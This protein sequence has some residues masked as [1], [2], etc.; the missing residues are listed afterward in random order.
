MER[1]TGTYGTITINADGTYPMH[2]LQQ[3]ILVKIT[4]SLQQA[5]R[6]RYK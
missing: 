1:G 5:D 3:F 2:Q 6:F 4:K